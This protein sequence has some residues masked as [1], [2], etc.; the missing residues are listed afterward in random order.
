VGLVTSLIF[1]LP[2]G[3]VGRKVGAGLVTIPFLSLPEGLVGRKVSAV[4]VMTFS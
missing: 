1:P 3:S 4:P 2:E